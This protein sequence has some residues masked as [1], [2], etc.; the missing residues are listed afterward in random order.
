MKVAKRTR[1]YLVE[2]F[3][4]AIRLR[5]P[6]LLERLVQ[7]ISALHNGVIDLLAEGR[8]DLMRGDAKNQLIC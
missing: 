3:S 7:A 4:L 5:R 2:E 1:P 6:V 8:E